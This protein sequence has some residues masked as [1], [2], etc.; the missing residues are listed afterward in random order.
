MRET[1][2]EEVVVAALK[3]PYP[4]PSALTK[5]D[6]QPQPPAIDLC[7]LSDESSGGAKP[8]KEKRGG[9]RKK[10]A[11]TVLRRAAKK[12]GVDDDDSDAAASA[13]KSTDAADRVSVSLEGSPDT[14]AT[15]HTPSPNKRASE[16]KK[17]PASGMRTLTSFFAVTASSAKKNTTTRNEN[18]SSSSVPLTPLS[19]KRKAGRDPVPLLV[20]TPGRASARPR[21]AAQAFSSGKATSE[22]KATLSSAAAAAT[23]TGKRMKDGRRPNSPSKE[24]I[25]A[26][27]LGT[28]VAKSGGA[29]GSG[30][31]SVPPSALGTPGVEGD[32]AARE[33][34]AAP[35]VVPP[36]ASM[37]ML[38]IAA[39]DTDSV[40]LMSDPDAIP[41]AAIVSQRNVRSTIE[42]QE[43]RAMRMVRIADAD[44]AGG[45]GGDARSDG[46]AVA[47][48]ADVDA[49]DDDDDG[50]RPGSSG[51]KSVAVSPS[52]Q[53]EENIDASPPPS[54][55][56]GDDAKA[57]SYSSPSKRG[58][59]KRR[60]ELT[61]VRKLDGE[62]GGPLVQND[63]GG[64]GGSDE[65]GSGGQQVLMMQ[66]YGD[67]NGGG[68][69]VATAVA[70][71]IPSW[72]GTVDHDH[73]GGGG[74]MALR[75]AAVDAGKRES[76]KGGEFK[77]RKLSVA[78]RLDF[79]PSASSAAV[80]GKDF[81]E[82][83][84]KSSPRKRTGK[85]G[86]KGEGKRKDP[87]AP[88]R[89][90]SAYLFFAAERRPELK[91]ES[92]DINFTEMVSYFFYPLLIHRVCAIILLGV[93]HRW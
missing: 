53:R 26:I 19:K 68:G 59:K 91:K 24:E 3:P 40:D 93:R 25:R 60:A 18:K 86:R 55:M 14:T 43:E 75:D 65:G 37:S 77:E 72:H 69:A 32:D 52:P 50:K 13:F 39:P 89:P 54:A 66:K 76:D 9:G 16:T 78:T 51:S 7:D 88:R 62:E 35:G 5:T 83:K 58:R 63:G 80:R 42:K 8:T 1:V 11:A 79:A 67:G 21:P 36:S 84:F 28:L 27:V 44:V 33:N 92:P 29:G 82:A 30:L 90:K 57:V 46:G 15:P 12:K 71:S 64:D 48:A 41:A 6:P 56:G 23:A 17:S 4:P 20:P 81:G 45:G 87:N 38:G 85:K 31:D 73:D 61:L 49:G 22:A 47:D 70:E 10:K 2:E 34:T 74:G